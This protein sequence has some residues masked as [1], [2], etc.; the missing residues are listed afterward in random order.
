MAH[1][2][3]AADDVTTVAAGARCTAGR[4]R[5]GGDAVAASAS[6]FA[7]CAITSSKFSAFYHFLFTLITAQVQGP[8]DPRE[9]T[10]DSGP[11]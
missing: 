6:A 8:S 4:G 5:G 7:S 9:H 3:A 2:G 10:L 11:V 1:L